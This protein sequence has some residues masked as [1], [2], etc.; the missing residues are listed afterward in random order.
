VNVGVI[1][2]GTGVFIIGANVG[3]IVTTL[4]RI[5]VAGAITISGISGVAVN[6]AFLNEGDWVIGV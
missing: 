1:I 5:V 2:L 6:N 4:G 3:P